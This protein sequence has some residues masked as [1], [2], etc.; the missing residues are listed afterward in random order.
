MYA[1]PDPASESLRMVRA[2]ASLAPTGNREGLF[3]EVD[4]GYGTT[5]WVSVEDLQ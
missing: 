3:I 2:G 1:S 5:G 4:D